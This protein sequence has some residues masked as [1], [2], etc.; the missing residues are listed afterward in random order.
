MPGISTLGDKVT[1]KGKTSIGGKND[2]IM[3][4]Q[5]GKDKTAIYKQKRKTLIH[6]IRPHKKQKSKPCTECKQYYGKILREEN[7]NV[8]ANIRGLHYAD[9]ILHNLDS[10]A[11]KSFH[12]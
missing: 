10:S 9:K 6:V 2:S 12:N 5:H 11:A 8:E 1:C 7:D 3:V 4:I